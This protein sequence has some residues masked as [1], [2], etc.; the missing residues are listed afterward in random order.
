MQCHTGNVHSKFLVP[1]MVAVQINVP[2]VNT[3]FSV[4]QFKGSVRTVFIGESRLSKK[5]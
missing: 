1:S 3:E 2:F 5:S 4:S